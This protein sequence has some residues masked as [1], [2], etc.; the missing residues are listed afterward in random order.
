MGEG[1]QQECSSDEG[2]QELHESRLL[3]SWRQICLYAVIVRRAFSLL[4]LHSQ[5]PAK[6]GLFLR[7]SHVGVD[8][9]FTQK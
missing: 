2:L 3:Y 7:K 5:E 1:G 8:A 4:T 9:L 6:C